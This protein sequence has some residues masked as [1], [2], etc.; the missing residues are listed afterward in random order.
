MN[1]IKAFIIALA[2]PCLFTSLLTA[3]SSITKTFPIN[4]SSAVEIE[5]QYGDIEI[6]KHN[7]SDVII[8][9]D[10]QVN[11]KQGAEHFTFD[12][13]KNGTTMILKSA[14]DFDEVDK[15][16][17][18]IMNDGKKIF[19]EEGNLTIQDIS[20]DE[21][22]DKVYNGIDIDA[23]FIVKIPSNIDLKAKTIYGNLMIKDYW[24]DMVIHSTYGSVDA[25]IKNST[26]A[27]VMKISS[28]Y[29]DVDVTIPESTNAAL[30]LTTDY[31]S[32]YTDL[33]LNPEFKTSS[34]KRHHGQDISA[35][36][37]SGKGSITLDAT[38]S[39]IYL[40]KSL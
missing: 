10:I 30:K 37:N 32:I 18:V 36:L 17:T 2:L 15:R 38:Y 27:P 23:K 28:T 24:Q 13:E 26:N 34:N 14:A 11:G 4:N 31:G 5:F 1:N 22:V 20:D 6:V 29:S 16:L 19:K 8:E 9:G 39:N 25:L 40:R 21:N 35:K 12:T 33:D 7:G 3:Q